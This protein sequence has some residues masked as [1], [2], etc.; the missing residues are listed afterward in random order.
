[1]VNANNFGDDGL[2]RLNNDRNPLYIF[3][4]Y[5]NLSHASKSHLLQRYRAYPV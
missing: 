3:H 4:K 2:E 1:M 5:A